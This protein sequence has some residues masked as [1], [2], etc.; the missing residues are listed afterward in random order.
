[1]TNWITT[2]WH[3]HSEAW[4]AI[5]TP[6]ASLPLFAL[7]SVVGNFVGSDSKMILFGAAFVFV[8]ERVLS[9]RLDNHLKAVNE[10]VF[11]ATATAESLDAQHQADA[12]REKRI[13]SWRQD[14]EDR[15]RELEAWRTRHPMR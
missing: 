15:I 1:M 9:K 3:N 12:D 10:Q 13:A 8:V 11:R 7:A 6:I 5:T 14:H 2:W 4:H